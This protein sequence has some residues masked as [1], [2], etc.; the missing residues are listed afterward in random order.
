[1]S[2]KRQCFR[3][4]MKRGFDAIYELIIV[5]FKFILSFLIIG[6]PILAFLWM[7]IILFPV[8]DIS[9]LLPSIIFVCI[10][11]LIWVFY[12]FCVGLPYINCYIYSELDSPTDSF[13][14]K[15][16]RKT[17]G[18]GTYCAWCGSNIMKEMLE[19]KNAIE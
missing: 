17:D 18:S 3:K 8:S 4:E 19:I 11:F 9:N 14:P 5:F 13:C 16:G 1:M 7:D 2:D 12:V 15:C 6:L 10:T